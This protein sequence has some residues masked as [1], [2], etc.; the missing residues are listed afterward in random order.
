MFSNPAGQHTRVG[1]Y[2]PVTKVYQDFD[3]INADFGSHVLIDSGFIYVGADSLLVKYDLNTKMKLATRTVKGIREMAVWGNQILVTCGTTYPL[4]AYFQAYD[5]HTFALVYQDTTVS[6]ATEGIQVLDDSAYIAINDFGSGAVG[7]LGVVDL[8]AK[9]EKHE[10]DLGVNGLNPYSVFVEPASKKVYTLNDLTWSNATVTQYDAPTTVYNNTS[11]HLSSGCTGSVYY[12]GN[13]YFQARNDDNVGL[14]SP[15]LRQFGIHLKYINSFM[16]WELIR[17]T[18]IF[19]SDK[20]TMFLMETYLFMISSDMPST[21]L[22]YI[23][24]EILVRS[25]SCYRSATNT[26]NCSI[27]KCVSGIPHLP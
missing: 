12:K 5:K 23:G 7:K 13:V 24:P 25:K 10:V 22:H 19:I 6:H 27:C 2:N 18:D 14:F 1:S 26:Y 11:L 15:V 3:T 17:L 20:P 4:K 8:K 9:K 16:E 21:L